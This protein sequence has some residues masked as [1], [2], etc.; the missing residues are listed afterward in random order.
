MAVKRTYDFALTLAWII[1][2][3]GGVAV[4]VGGVS[5]IV[6]IVGGL[7][8]GAPV[9]VFGISLLAWGF[10]VVAGAQLMQAVIDT[11]RNTAE[12]CDYLQ[13]TAGNRPEP[14]V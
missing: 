1:S 2:L 12:M 14:K 11:A 3:L 13:Q 4:V 6:A 7:E 10:T 5:I 8:K 9:L